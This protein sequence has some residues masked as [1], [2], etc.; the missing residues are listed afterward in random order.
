MYRDSLHLHYWKWSNLKEFYIYEKEKKLLY[1]SVYTLHH[2][3]DFQ[4]TSR[5]GKYR[6]V[7]FAVTRCVLRRKCACV[8]TRVRENIDKWGAHEVRSWESPLVGCAGCDDAEDHDRKWITLVSHASEANDAKYLKG[9]VVSHW[10]ALDTKE[11]DELVLAFLGVF[12]SDLT[13]C[14]SCTLDYRMKCCAQWIFYLLDQG[15]I[16]GMSSHAKNE[17]TMIVVE[18]RIRSLPR[19][20]RS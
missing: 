11:L 14:F 16:F 3:F 10:R 1:Y 19:H 4:V 12:G 20:L 2:N 17:K 13:T 6:L 7:S 8:I 9:S 18:S 15:A 5:T